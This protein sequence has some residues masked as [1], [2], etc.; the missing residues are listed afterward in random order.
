LG[1]AGIIQRQEDAGSFVL[2]GF[3]GEKSLPNKGTLRFAYAQSHGEIMGS[4]NFFGVD[5]STH[6][7]NAFLIELNQPLTFYQG[8][9][10][11][12]YSYSSEGFLNPFGA[13]VTPGSRYGEA[14][15]EFK[16]RAS[17]LLRFGLTDEHNRT[18]AVDNSRLTFSARWEQSINDR[19]RFQ[20]GFDHRSFDDTL[21]LRSI[22]S[23]LITAGAELKL[24]D[25]LQVA[26]KREQ[27]LGDADPTYPDQTTLAATYQVNQWA[28]LFLTQR[29]ASAPILP[30]GDFSGSGFTS[31]GARRETA[32]GIETKLGKHSALTGR[33]QLENGI[34]GTDSFA[35]I[36][37]QNRLPLTKEFS[38]E[39]GFERGFHVA[40]NG[41]SFNSATIGFG[42]QPNED[43]RSSARYE[44]RDRTG[45]GQ[46]L[47]L[48]AAG[49]ITE[50]MTVLSRLQWART[51]FEG[52]RNSSIE[53]T[54]ALAI[55]PLSSDRAALMFSYT[56][57]SLLRDAIIGSAET[58][59]RLD[60]LATDGYF[61]ATDR[62]ELYG[63]LA[64]RFNANGQPDLP[65]VST[66]TYLTQGRAQY[67]LTRRVDW[68]GEVRRLIQPSSGTHRSLYGSEIGFWALPDLRLGFG[69]NF[70]ATGEPQGII[71][72]PG[73]RGFYF[74]LTS[75]LS[76]LFDLFGT[77][78]TGLALSDKNDKPLAADKDKEGPKK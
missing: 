44:F 2:G 19:L 27:N 64:L 49:R 50:G 14:S 48:G 67:R 34:N 58:R 42:W 5:E 13:T 53:G 17:T 6:N 77:S 3:D 38:L 18:A 72:L 60:G 35:V 29:L 45:G 66:F 16:P 75:K 36:G 1:F 11:A 74:T 10:R 25:K 55:R 51:E 26:V 52:R 4:G 20:L 33:Y 40:G 43:F 21:N 22:E 8:L 41:D 32:L 65:F 47:A 63:R 12:R 57:R 69:Y 24:T 37:L 61:Q 39:L 76:K 23:N 30:I 59:D 62:L 28:R 71:G 9:I 46:L 31:T 78:N 54:A 15:F 70:S 73:N 56:H 68:A 7:G